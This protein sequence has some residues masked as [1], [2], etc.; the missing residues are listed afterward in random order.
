M[1]FDEKTVAENNKLI[2]LVPWQSKAQKQYKE[3]G[4]DEMEM[5]STITAL[6]DE[7]IKLDDLSFAEVAV[8]DVVSLKISVVIPHLQREG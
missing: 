5:R 6:A 3:R 8:N 4:L 7:T 2:A 1:E